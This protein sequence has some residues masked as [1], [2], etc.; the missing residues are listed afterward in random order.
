MQPLLLMKQTLEASYD[1]GPLLLNGPN[2]K[3]TSA[4]QFISRLQKNSDS[5]A[6]SIGIE[7]AKGRTLKVVFSLSNNQTLEI[8]KMVIG[9]DKRSLCLTPNQKDADLE[10]AILTSRLQEVRWPK[11]LKP[12]LSVVK[13][14]CFLDVNF[15][16]RHSVSQDQQA[17]VAKDVHLVEAALATDRLITSQDERVRSVLRTASNNVGELKRIVWVNPIRGDETPTDWLRDGAKTEEHRLLGS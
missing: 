1:L 14:R 9:E 3:F 8:Q 12:S 10:N 15:E 11:Q 6:F 2:A 4:N 7:R 17:M 5:Q 16:G 13:N